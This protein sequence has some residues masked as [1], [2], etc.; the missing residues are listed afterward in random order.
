MAKRA[1]DNSTRELRRQE[2]RDLLLRVMADSLAHGDE[3]IPVSEIAKK[4]G[5]STR[6]V[7]VHFPDRAS[8][9]DGI[10]AW[11]D[12]QV[13]MTGV[14]PTTLE[15]LQEYG[16][17][18]VDYVLHNETIMRAQMA[19]GL[20]RDVRTLRKQPHITAV[21]EILV[22][23]GRNRR[24]SKRIAT[25]LVATV[26]AEAIFDLRDTYEYSTNQIRQMMST[27]TANLL[28]I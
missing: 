14:L 17:R 21:T 26:R 23:A 10:N 24:E 16:A 15:D 7:Y 2:T 6:T 20:S 19:P 5:V 8:R 28:E 18:L 12:E 1:Y 4:A 13:D 11:I 25:L 3:D 22:S 27:L 9:I